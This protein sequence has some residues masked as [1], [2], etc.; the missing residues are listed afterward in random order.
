MLTLKNKAAK[1]RTRNQMKGSCFKFDFMVFNIRRR[2]VF[3]IQN[4]IRA[5]STR[6]SMFNEAKGFSSNITLTA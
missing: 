4:V 1:K 3:E 5:I 6:L 2:M